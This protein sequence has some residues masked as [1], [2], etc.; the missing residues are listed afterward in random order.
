MKENVIDILMYLLQNASMEEEAVEH[1]QETLKALLQDAGYANGEI[2]EAFRWLDDL[3]SQISQQLAIKQ[4]DHS[5]R[6]FSATEESLLDTH[7]RDYLLGLVNTGI[8]TPNSFELV[9]DRLLALGSDDI[10]LSQLEW[11]V[12]IV[13]SN[14]SDQQEA[15]QRLEAMRFH[16]PN[17]RLN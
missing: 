12:L 10:D 1:D 11:V 16:E 17:S 7:C 9:I 3:G 15:F 2:H 13:L 14:Q 6:C 8:L 5:F 4:A